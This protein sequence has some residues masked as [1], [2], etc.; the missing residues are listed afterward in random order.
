MIDFMLTLLIQQVELQ[1]EPAQRAQLYLASCAL[2]GEVDGATIQSVYPICQADTSFGTPPDLEQL[3][4]YSENLLSRLAMPIDVSEGQFNAQ[5]QLIW[6]ADRGWHLPEIVPVLRTEPSYPPRARADA[7]NGQCA[8]TVRVQANGTAEMDEWVC[9]A[10]NR[11]NRS[12]RTTY[13]ERAVEDAVARTRWI[14]PLE[15]EQG[16]ASLRYN[17]RREDNWRRVK[18]GEEATPSCPD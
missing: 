5:F 14:L 17:F 10:R 13:F 11:A 7:I 12:S 15:M 9:E 3:Q 1:D 18:V 8:G 2:G 16:C 4:V 6:L